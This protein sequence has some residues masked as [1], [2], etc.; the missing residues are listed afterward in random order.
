[1]QIES[2]TRQFTQFMRIEVYLYSKT[3]GMSLQARV[4]DAVE[5]TARDLM[6]EGPPEELTEKKRYSHGFVTILLEAPAPN[7]RILVTIVE[8]YVFCQGVMEMLVKANHN[9]IELGARMFLRGQLRAKV[10]LLFTSL[11]AAVEKPLASPVSTAE[12][13][14]E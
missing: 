1:M 7:A 8:L 6:E 12:L 11:D 14:V 5:S 2:F 9:P 10:S 4:R 3:L 13:T